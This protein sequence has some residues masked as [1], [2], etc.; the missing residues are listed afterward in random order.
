M[1]RSGCSGVS[2]EYAGVN[3]IV[4]PRAMNSVIGVRQFPSRLAC[5]KLMVPRGQMTIINTYTPHSGY[6]FDNRQAFYSDL[7]DMH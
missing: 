1:I 5:L 3:F 7:L 2:K 4:A 6:R